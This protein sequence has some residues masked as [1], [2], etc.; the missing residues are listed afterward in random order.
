MNLDL[1][2]AVDSGLAHVAGAL[3]CPVWCLLP[4]A[5]DSR[6]TASVDGTTPRYP[7]HRLYA[8]S[9][10]GGWASVVEEVRYDLEQAIL[11]GSLNRTT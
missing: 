8:Q 9:R 10:P 11:H 6:W 7:G 1:L 2:V 5:Y 4:F 3:G